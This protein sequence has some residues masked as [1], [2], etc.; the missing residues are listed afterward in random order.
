MNLEFALKLFPI[1]LFLKFVLA[2]PLCRVFALSYGS[3]RATIVVF[4]AFVVGVDCARGN[5]GNVVSWFTYNFV[6]F[7][8]DEVRELVVTPNIIQ[9]VV[10]D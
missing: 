7:P 2:F 8:I 9:F 3:R 4:L 1:C 10:S 6:S 5:E